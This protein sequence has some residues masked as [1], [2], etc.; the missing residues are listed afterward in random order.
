MERVIIE[1]VTRSPLFIGRDALKVLL[2]AGVRSVQS[3]PLISRSGKLLGIIS[4]H[5]SKI[6]VLPER[7]LM[8]FDILARQAADIIEHEQGKQT[9][10]SNLIL[11]GINRIFSIVVQD[12]TE[13]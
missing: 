9:H 8:L 3:T 6:H 12:K 4:T 2:N 5:F 13:E 7:E 10:R 11:E 1:D